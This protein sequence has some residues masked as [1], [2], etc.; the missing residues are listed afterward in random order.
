[1]SKRRQKKQPNLPKATLERARQQAGLEDAEENGDTGEKDAEVAKPEP[2][3]TAPPARR[4]KLS[5]AQLERSRQRGELDAEMISAMLAN[6]TIVVTEQQ[7]R[8]EYQH[9]LLDLRNMGLLAAALMLL[10]VVL[11][12]FI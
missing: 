11:A 6:P 5:P 4:R 3:V 9:V 2:V 12:Q 8:E 7:L 1:M 10:L